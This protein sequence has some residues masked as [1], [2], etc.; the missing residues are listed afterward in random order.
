MN[1]FADIFAPVL[2]LINKFIPDPDAK[3]KAIT[4]F[5]NA[6]LQA[7]AIL[8]TTDQKQLDVNAIEAQ[9]PNIFKSG[10]RPFVGWTCAIALFNDTIIREILSLFQI[11]MASLD[12][13][14]VTQLLT[15]LLGIAGY[16]T[17]EKFKGVA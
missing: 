7:M 12:S 2:D 3:K 16:R 1:P 11:S 5:N 15:G 6:L 10:W 4:A 17:F 13:V 9:S 8:S 14:L